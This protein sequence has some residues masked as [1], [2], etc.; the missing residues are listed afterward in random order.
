MENEFTI[1]RVKKRLSSYRDSI[2]AIS[3]NF[4]SATY[5]RKEELMLS[6][7]KVYKEI[8]SEKDRAHKNDGTDIDIETTSYLP[9]LQEASKFLD[10]ALDPDSNQNILS[11]LNNASFSLGYYLSHG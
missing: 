8:E 11:C 4:E 5:D 9:A 10:Q 6:I 7:E 3:E 2:E 1:T